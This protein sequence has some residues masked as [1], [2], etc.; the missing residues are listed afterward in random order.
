MGSIPSFQLT[1]PCGLKVPTWAL[2]VLPGLVSL[3]ARCPI[4]GSCTPSGRSDPEGGGLRQGQDTTALTEGPRGFLPDEVFAGV[5]S[6]AEDQEGILETSWGEI[7]V[8]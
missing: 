6:G 7:V 1:L 2:P 5:R 4:S 3:R 8:Y